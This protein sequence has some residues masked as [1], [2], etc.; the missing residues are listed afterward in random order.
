M[1]NRITGSAVASTGA[2]PTPLMTLL[3]GEFAHRA[4]RLWP[5][6]HV[7]FVTA[8]AARRHLV[9]MAF[10]LGRDVAALRETLLRG[11]LRRAIPTVLG[12]LL[13][14]LERALTRMSE[15]SWAAAD[16]RALLRLLAEPRAAKVLRHAP[17]L[18]ADLVRRLAALPPPMGDAV[19]LALELNAEGVAVLEEAYAALRF[20]DGATAAEAAAARWAR[21]RSAKALFEAVRDDLAPEPLAPPHPGTPRL[22]PL[23]TKRALRSA[24]RL[25]RNCLADRAPYAATGWSAYY[26][27]E[28]PPGAIVEITRD[29]VFGWRLEEARAAHNAPV[30]EAV[31]DEIVSELALMGVH[32]GRSGWELHRALSPDIGVRWPL[33]PA[34]DAVLE[35]FGA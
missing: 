26:E 7:E 25:Y 29:H 15:V 2:G 12:D 16:Y 9:C 14:G 21:T 28:G 27:W 8:S 11:R 17:A 33:R 24:A 13:P 32:V 3:A 22:R 23:A 1:F 19:D 4:A 6:P 20:R 31:R 34:G 18:E 30:P 35:A 5:A 10:T